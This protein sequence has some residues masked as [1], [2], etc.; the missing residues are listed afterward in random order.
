[1]R[2]VYI[3]KFILGEKIGMSQIFDKEGNVIPVTI[4]GAAPNIMLQARTKE[5][6]G[7]EALQVGFG[8]R[9]KKNIKKQQQGHFKELGNFR[10]VR[11]FRTGDK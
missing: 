11:E 6:D 1:M 10:Y 4:V 7:Y 3:M 2:G 8:E 9:K 5:K